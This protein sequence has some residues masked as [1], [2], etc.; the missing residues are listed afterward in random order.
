MSRASAV[1]AVEDAI[2]LEKDLLSELQ[3][4]HKRADAKRDPHVCATQA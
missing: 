1:D 2:K 4:L 3:L